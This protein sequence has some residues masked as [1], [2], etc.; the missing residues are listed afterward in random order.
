MDMG[1]TPDIRTDLAIIAAILQKL[2][3]IIDRAVSQMKALTI[4][5]VLC[6]TTSL[7]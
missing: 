3:G 5:L 6:P 1:L 7:A 4:R 2:G